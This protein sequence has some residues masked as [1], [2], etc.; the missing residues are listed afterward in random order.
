[1]RLPDGFCDAPA[2]RAGRGEETQA[3]PEGPPPLGLSLVLP[4]PNQ[5]TPPR[6]KA[7]KLGAGTV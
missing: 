2:T 1:M 6:A 4:E 3:S 7:A 5:G